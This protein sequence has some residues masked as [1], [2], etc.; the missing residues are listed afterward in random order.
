MRLAANPIGLG[1][2]A[3][4]LAVCSSC[5]R[6]QFAE[7]IAPAVV[8]VE[9]TVL[10]APA[11]ANRD[12]VKLPARPKASVPLVS[13]DRG[14]VL[15]DP[16]LSFGAV[17]FGI[18]EASTARLNGSSE[19]RS[20]AAIARTETF[21]PVWWF[22]SPETAFELVAVVNRLGGAG[23]SV[24][25]VELQERLA[26][27]R[28]PQRPVRPCIR[29]RW[30]AA[31]DHCQSHQPPQLGQHGP[32][33]QRAAVDVLRPGGGRSRRVQVSSRGQRPPTRLARVVSRTGADEP[34]PWPVFGEYRRSGRS[35]S[36]DLVWRLAVVGIVRHHSVVLGDVD[37]DDGGYSQ[38][39]TQ[40]LSQRRDEGTGCSRRRRSSRRVAL[41]PGRPRR[42]VAEPLTRRPPV[43]RGVGTDAR[44]HP[45][46]EPLVRRA[47]PAPRDSGPATYRAPP[48]T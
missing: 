37:V 23:S 12:A 13:I 1:I 34:A 21:P 5:S 24:G 47:A 44:V 32:R 48:E 26:T 2:L 36:V 14:D 40:R 16:E 19:F 35:N 20:L 39:V 17:V 10:H 9:Q 42:P 25:G 7:P 4:T 29:R 18:N 6:D 30:R 22:R 41:G 33:D 28:G 46:V 43:P 15:T 27:R 3:T 8:E 38:R 11:A 45:W 31:L